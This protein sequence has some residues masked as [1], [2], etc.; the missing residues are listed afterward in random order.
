MCPPG[1]AIAFASLRRTTLMSSG[2]ASPAAASSR[3]VSRASAARP[4]VS[5]GPAP[6]SNGRPAGP[7]SSILRACVSTASPSSRST[8]SGTKRRDLVR[9]RRHAE[10]SREQQRRGRRE[11]PADDLEPSAARDAAAAVDRHGSF[12]DRVGQRRI[13]HLEARELARAARSRA[14]ARPRAPRDDRAGRRASAPACRDPRH[15]GS[16]RRR[17]QAPPARRAARWSRRRNRCPS[18][19]PRIVKFRRH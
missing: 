14:A 7:L 3:A 18:R 1:N 17:R 8:R 4:C 6:H 13:A 12:V 11:A 19:Q 10:D 5:P 16:R 9:Q 2:I 15:R